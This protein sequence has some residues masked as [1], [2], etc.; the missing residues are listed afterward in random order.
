M[1]Y[2]YIPGFPYMW[3]DCLLIQKNN[4]YQNTHLIIWKVHEL[5]CQACEIQEDG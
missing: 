5:K 3:H 1:P 2:V 4:K